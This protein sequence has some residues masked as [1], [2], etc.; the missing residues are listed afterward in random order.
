MWLAH[1]SIS[2]WVADPATM[3]VTIHGTGQEPQRFGRDDTLIDEP[4][5]PGFQLPLR[6]IFVLP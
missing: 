5:L 2:V 4:L 3:S 6:R 1:D